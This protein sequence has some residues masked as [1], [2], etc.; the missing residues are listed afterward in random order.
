[1][2]GSGQEY[3][4]SLKK[5][6]DVPNIHQNKTNRLLNNTQIKSSKSILNNNQI[7]TLNTKNSSAD[8]LIEYFEG[9]MLN[10]I[11]L[12]EEQGKRMD[13]LKNLILSHKKD[14]FKGGKN[15]Y[16]DNDP[17]YK[18][19]T[20]D[21][22]KTDIDIIKFI[23]IY[24]SFITIEI[25]IDYQKEYYI[26]IKHRYA[27]EG[28]DNNLI[29]NNKIDLIIDLQHNAIIDKANRLRN[30]DISINTINITYILETITKKLMEYE[31]ND[32]PVVLKII[33]KTQEKPIKNTNDEETC[34]KS[35]ISLLIMILTL[36]N[37]VSKDVYKKYNTTFLLS[38]ICKN[39]LLKKFK[40][41][42]Y[43]NSL[44]LFS[45]NNKNIL[46]YIEKNHMMYYIGDCALNSLMSVK[47][48]DIRELFVDK[49]SY[50]VKDK[51]LDY[52]ND[53]K[54]YIEKINNVLSQMKGYQLEDFDFI[55]SITKYVNEYNDF[56]TYLNNN[57]AS[58]K[59]GLKDNINNITLPQ[60]CKDSFDK[61]HDYYLK[62]VNVLRNNLFDYNLMTSE[63]REICKEATD[64]IKR[65]NKLI[66]S[67]KL[68]KNTLGI[69]IFISILDKYMKYENS[70]C[71]FYIN[72]LISLLLI[73]YKIEY[74]FDEDT[75]N[76][77]K[78][79]DNKINIIQCFKN[80]S[81]NRNEIGEILP[82]YQPGYGNDKYIFIRANLKDEP[83]AVFLIVDI[84]SPNKKMYLYDLNRLYL[85]CS[86]DFY[87]FDYYE[88]ILSNIYVYELNNSY[89]WIRHE[90]KNYE[91]HYMNHIM[92]YFKNIEDLTDNC[93]DSLLFENIIKDNLNLN[94]INIYNDRGNLDFTK[95]V[96][97]NDDDYNEN[98]FNFIS[99]NIKRQLFNKL[100]N[101]SNIIN[102]TDVNVCFSN[103]VN[104]IS[105]FVQENI[106]DKE[107]CSIGKLLFKFIE[108]LIKAKWVF[109]NRAFLPINLNKEYYKIKDYFDDTYHLI[110]TQKFV[111]YLGFTDNLNNYHVNY[112][113]IIV[114][115]LDTLT[116]T[117]PSKDKIVRGGYSNINYNNI[118]KRVL[119]ILLII[120]IIIIIVLIVLFIINKYNIPK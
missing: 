97:L 34:I 41:D 29:E 39:Q 54:Y 83:H 22:T 40:D 109:D 94:N 76:I 51:K 73:K 26:N 78:H 87:E 28:K 91:P 105:K 101:Y 21:A 112:N 13:E 20:D 14:E 50:G 75:M 111:N 104:F 6:L 46:T 93:S 38:G 71:I 56:I 117:H 81:N 37:N 103:A 35:V 17:E 88:L 61:L 42:D 47:N 120:V 27:T 58:L 115:I 84:G 23:N 5:G 90:M 107:S 7:K 108:C 48:A 116:F 118:I 19:Y 95:L 82:V 32:C 25:H 99:Y 63:A 44:R 24:W 33:D 55:N 45:G 96:T 69:R 85:V 52:N 119:I 43:N 92:I 2:F 59:Q 114:E 68:Y 18:N 31:Y 66:E 113:K 98:N 16:L 110:N 60:D 49:I 102:N 11:S 30:D 9:I 15:S 65:V 8:Y 79:T 36:K 64:N 74:L 4:N 53:S 67:K 70:F 80:I 106:V 3:L 1:M 62:F 12:V 89:R 100:I 72:L 86:E 77:L 57:Y 10:Y